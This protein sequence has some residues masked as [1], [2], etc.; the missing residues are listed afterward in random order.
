MIPRGR[1]LNIGQHEITMTA[2]SR[3]ANENRGIASKAT[4]GTLPGASHI[5]ITDPSR[6]H[7]SYNADPFLIIDATKSCVWHSR[8]FWLQ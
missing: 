5:P 4:H 8:A 3:H 6:I 7:L 2:D 1:V